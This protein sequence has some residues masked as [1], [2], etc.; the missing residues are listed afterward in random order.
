MS[1][2]QALDEDPHYAPAWARLARIY[3]VM[4]MYSGEDADENYALADAAFRR[5]LEINPDLSIAHNLFTLVEVETGRAREAMLRL[6]MLGE[7]G[8]GPPVCAFV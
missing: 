2:R 4:A 3:R 5:A 1:A 6:G 8:G 7:P